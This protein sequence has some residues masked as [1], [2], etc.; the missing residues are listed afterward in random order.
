[1]TTEQKRRH[2]YNLKYY[3]E[4]T[5]KLKANN[6]AYRIENRKRV[7]L[8]LLKTLYGRFGWT[9]EWH[10]AQLK[11]YKK[12]CAI[13]RKKRRLCVDHK[14]KNLRGL[15]CNNCNTMLGFICDSA[16]SLRRAVTYVLRH[17]GKL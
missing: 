14:G 11:K 13:C 2:V 3:K 4:H 10:K 16:D 15:L 12:R 7:K 8:S 6:K 9:P 17:R 1:M 5:E